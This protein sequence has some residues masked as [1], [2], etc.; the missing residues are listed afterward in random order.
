[1]GEILHVDAINQRID[2]ELAK[3]KA[4]YG[5]RHFDI[6]VLEN[7]RGDTISDRIFW[8]RYASS[9]RRDRARESENRLQC[10]ALASVAFPIAI[11]TY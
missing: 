5:P 3:A 4:K 1:M 7:S 10:A 9:T 8:L 6:I 2:E 11:G